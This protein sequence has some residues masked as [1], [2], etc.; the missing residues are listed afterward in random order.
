MLRADPDQRGRLEEIATNLQERL[1]EARDRGWLGEVEGIE[2]SIAA[3][4]DKLAQMSRQVD[5]GLPTIR[6]ERGTP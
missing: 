3:A 6:S 2:V 1:T 5:L 4:Q